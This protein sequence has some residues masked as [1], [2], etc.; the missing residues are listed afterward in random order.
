LNLFER[1]LRA[2]RLLNGASDPH[3][4]AIESVDTEPTSRREPLLLTAEDVGRL[5]QV[6]AATVHNLHRLGRLRGV[7][8][9]RELRWRFADVRRFVDELKPD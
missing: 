5:L 1:G 9:G 7:R 8:V 4:E 2:L 6:E 3:L